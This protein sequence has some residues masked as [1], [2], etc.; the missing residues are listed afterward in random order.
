MNDTPIVITKDVIKGVRADKDA[1]LRKALKIIE[2]EK[3]KQDYVP[4]VIDK[5]IEKIKKELGEE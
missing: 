5:I 2:E 4:S 1:G 3:S